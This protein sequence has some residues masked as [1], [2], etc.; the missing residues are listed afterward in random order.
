MSFDAPLE[1][2][3]EE[4]IDAIPEKPAAETPE[5]AENDAPV[6][7]QGI[8][9]TPAIPVVPEPAVEPAT[10]IAPIA[11]A[12]QIAP[13]APAPIPVPPTPP[14][15]QERDAHNAA[16]AQ[17]LATKQIAP[18]SFHDLYADKSTV[19]KIS[20]IFGLM[21]AGA[22][23]GLTGQPNALLDMMNKEIE[24]DLESQ[25]QNV[26]NKQSF[27]SLSYAHEL[28]N[29]QAKKM[30]Y[31]NELTKQQALGV[32]AENA[33]KAELNKAK[34][35][36]GKKI[37][38]DLSDPDQGPAKNISSNE[39][40]PLDKAHAKVAAPNEAKNAMY[41]TVY[42]D[43]SDKFA[44]DPK[45]QEFLKTYMA[46]AMMQQMAQN[47]AQTEA[48]TNIVSTMAEG[49]NASPPN[50]DAG[51]DINKMNKMITAGRMDSQLPPSKAIPPSDVPAVRQAQDKVANNRNLASI[52]NDSFHK[53]TSAVAAGTFNPEMRK[54]E[55]E[56]VANRIAQDTGVQS[57][58]GLKNQIDGMFPSAKDM[59]FP[60]A[61]SEKFRKAMEHF[62]GQ[63]AGTQILDSYGLKTPFPEYN[64]QEKK[65]AT[66][67]TDNVA[68]ETAPI[69][70][71]TPSG[72]TALFDPKTKK[73][74]RYKNDTSTIAGQ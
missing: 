34:N 61:R 41:M 32:S 30:A 65:K 21:L 22:G 27:L 49:Q 13:A 74:L 20:T 7:D 5:V 36:Y 60:N 2:D 57:T 67:N 43:L 12:P 46:P 71:Q 26:A 51:V 16:F 37:Y 35:L 62:K 59:V 23:S 63:E 40:T 31:E 52:Y 47:N 1:Q 58:E 70:R 6:A 10:Q 54:A 45:A 72:Q 66:T 11:A 24:R 38:D 50:G 4:N 9:D 14:T 44:N 19:G 28:Q 69:E 25:K 15:A 64:Y 53:L 17:D 8:A 18:K 29:A 39:P 48:K 33:G 68:T 42:Q 55:I 56:S 3:Q 73:F